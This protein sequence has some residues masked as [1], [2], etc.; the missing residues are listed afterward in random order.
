LWFKAIRPYLKTHPTQNRT[1]GVAEV[2]EC[3]L[4]NCEVLSS[5]P[6]TSKKKLYKE[7]G[8]PHENKKDDKNQ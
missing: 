8:K 4:N 7:S 1:G 5:K 6:S 3:P 2:V